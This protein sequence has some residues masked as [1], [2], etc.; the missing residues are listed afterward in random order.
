MTFTTAIPSE[1]KLKHLASMA[2]SLAHRLEVA[3]ACHN[4]QLS[5]LLE[6]EYE[7]LILERGEARESSSPFS[8]LDSIRAGLQNLWET[9][10]D[11]SPQLYQLQ[12]QQT[13]SEDGREGWFVYNPKSG[14]SL[15]TDS[16]IEMQNWI[17][18]TYWNA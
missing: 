6:R 14:Q 16:E 15:H 12:V 11:L 2:N 8:L 13:V 10:A 9:W 5:A 4:E 18:K 17:Q 3:R 1:L 7:Q